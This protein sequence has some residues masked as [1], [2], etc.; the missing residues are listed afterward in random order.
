MGWIRYAIACHYPDNSGAVYGVVYGV[1][2][3]VVYGAIARAKLHQYSGR[4]EN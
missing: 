1:V 3:G 2:C 4:F